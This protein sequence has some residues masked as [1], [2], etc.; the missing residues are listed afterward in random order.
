MTFL[1][2]QLL[3]LFF[4]IMVYHIGHGYKKKENVHG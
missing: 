1:Q 2:K 4:D 3:D